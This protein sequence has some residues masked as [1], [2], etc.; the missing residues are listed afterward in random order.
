MDP[1]TGMNGPKQGQF[2]DFLAIVTQLDA[3]LQLKLLN[4]NIKSD[5]IHFQPWSRHLCGRADIFLQ[6]AG[7]NIR[8][9]GI[10]RAARL[11]WLYRN[12]KAQ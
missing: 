12:G 1:L 11:A 7:A 5:R 9:G 4:D 8:R 6:Y 10:E 3:K 2:C